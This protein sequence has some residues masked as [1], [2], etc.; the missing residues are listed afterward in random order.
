[1]L[2]PLD[3][4]DLHVDYFPAIE[5]AFNHLGIRIDAN[6]KAI[7][8]LRIATF[9]EEYYL[10]LRATVFNQ[11]Q[12]KDEPKPNFYFNPDNNSLDQLVKKIEENQIDITQT[13]EAWF[14]I[15][16]SLA[17]T[18]G[19][20]GRKYFHSISRFYD[21]YEQD[22]TNDQFSEC[23]KNAKQDGDGYKLGTIFHYAKEY[24]LI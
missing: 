9:D 3:N 17:N 21:G 8:R 4:P 18:F 7:T 5:S 11:I 12:I 6:C 15:G 22:K 2:I 19:E 24:G 10:P 20:G 23:L 14:G 1:M 16:C 13:Y